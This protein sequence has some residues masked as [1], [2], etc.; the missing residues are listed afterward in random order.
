MEPAPDDLGALGHRQQPVA[1][2]LVA[3]QRAF[4]RVEADA[5]VDT[6]AIADLAAAED[7]YGFDPQGVPRPSADAADLESL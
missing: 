2:H 3:A 1:A 6:D 4:Q 5:V 7:A